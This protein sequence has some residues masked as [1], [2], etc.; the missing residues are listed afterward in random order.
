MAIVDDEPGVTRDRLYAMARP[1]GARFHLIDTGGLDPDNDHL[2]FAGMR[3]QARLAIEEADVVIH[4]C[5]AR[6]GLHPDDHYVSE[7][8]RKQG[9]PTITVANKVE[10]NV[11]EQLLPEIHGLGVEEVLPVSAAHGLGIADLTEAILRKVGPEMRKAAEAR[12]DEEDEAPKGRAARRAAKEA[13]DAAAPEPEAE[14]RPD[15]THL[16]DQLAVAVVGRPN[17]GKSSLINVLLGQPRLMVSDIPGTTRDAVDTL[18]TREGRTYRIVDT[19]GLRRKRTVARK[20]EKFSVVAAIRAL[21]DAH[22]VVLVMDGYEGVL[23]QD[24]K[25]AQLAHDAGKALILVINK[26]D[27]VQEGANDRKKYEARVLKE[28]GFVAYAPVLFVSALRK[29]GVD[30]LLPLVDEVAHHHFRRVGTGPLNKA[31]ERAQQAH[32]MPSYH[33][34]RVNM[35]YATQVAIAPP[36]MVVACN[37]PEGV[38]YSY[39]RFLQNALREE[40]GFKGTQL[41]LHFRRRGKDMGLRGHTH[42]KR[43]DPTKHVRKRSA[44]KA[45]D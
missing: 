6:D 42:R 1:A 16:P 41:R 28:L 14:G 18:L 9:K 39:K 44:P 8:L 35:Y 25:I 5:D 30:A 21:E 32:H 7:L 4:V 31:F 13:E 24:A 33:G 20:L 11:G 38:H 43:L 23:E 45:H 34:R 19:A 17:A 37:M 10:G 15:E 22:V 29:R 12:A 40:F 2:F 3:E 26:W 36:T 27:L